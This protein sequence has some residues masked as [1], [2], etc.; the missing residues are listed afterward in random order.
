MG[1]FSCPINLRNSAVSTFSN[2]RAL[3]I[4]NPSSSLPARA[5]NPVSR[6]TSNTWGT[7]RA[8]V[9]GSFSTVFSVS[10]VSR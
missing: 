10:I 8:K 1:D 6:F 5:M 9:S 7:S 4:V 3:S 2:P